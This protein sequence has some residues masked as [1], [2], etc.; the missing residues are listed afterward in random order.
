MHLQV[1]SSKWFLAKYER[2]MKLFR[3]TET[4]MADRQLRP[5]FQVLLDNAE[6]LEKDNHVKTQDQ[7]DIY[8][9]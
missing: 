7:N 3:A 9:Q 1:C 4:G 8:I 2:N 6:Q 5:Q